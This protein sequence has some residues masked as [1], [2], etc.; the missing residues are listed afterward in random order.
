MTTNISYY[1]T[2]FLV[3]N[4]LV[5]SYVYNLDPHI[6]CSILIYKNRI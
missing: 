6:L 4:L 1:D 3:D 5:Y 2:M